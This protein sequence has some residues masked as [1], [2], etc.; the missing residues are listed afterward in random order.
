MCGTG[1]GL[2]TGG[3]L[4]PQSSTM[5]KISRRIYPTIVITPFTRRYSVILTTTAYLFSPEAEVAPAACLDGVN[6]NSP[7]ARSKLKALVAAQTIPPN[8]AP[9]K[10]IVGVAFQLTFTEG[11]GN[12]GE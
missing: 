1:F 11:I 3:R 2:S 4:L 6:R 10:G 8:G 7:E 5:N 12:N 9:A